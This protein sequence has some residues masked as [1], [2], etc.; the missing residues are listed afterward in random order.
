MMKNKKW[1][2]LVLAAALV[3]TLAACEKKTQ[4]QKPQEPTTTQPTEPQKDTAA[5]IES[6]GQ[7]W[8]KTA[9]DGFRVLSAAIGLPKVTLANGETPMNL[10]NYYDN[11]LE[12]YLT[13]AQESGEIALEEYAD[14]QTSGLVFTPYDL[15]ADFTAACNRRGL[16]SFC[17]TVTEFTGGAHESRVILGESWVLR[18][19]DFYLLS[20]EDC[21]EEPEKAKTAIRD[22]IKQQAAEKAKTE[23]GYYFENY[24]ELLDSAWS[25]GDFYFT[26]NALCVVYQEYSLGPYLS[27][28]Q[29]FELPLAQLPNLKTEL[30]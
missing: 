4:P 12:K 1:I 20:L 26:E 5:K 23:D 21:F 7:T 15:E 22:L 28:A 29:V 19:G 24:E 17:R 25:E 9:D 13:Q 10:T 27:G 8:G 6:R 14:D 30:K 18:D 3:I 2:G 16:L 11:L